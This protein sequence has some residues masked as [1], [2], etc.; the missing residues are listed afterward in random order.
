MPYILYAVINSILL[1]ETR[2]ANG[3]ENT[4]FPPRALF[5]GN[6]QVF[7]S[8][9]EKLFSANLTGTRK[10]TRESALQHPNR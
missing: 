5:F 8:I 6:F 2:H 3:K 1:H 10:N 7:F 4:H 9:L